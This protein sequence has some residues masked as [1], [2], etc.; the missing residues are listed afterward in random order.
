MWRDIRRA[1]YVLVGVV[2]LLATITWVSAPDTR[3]PWWLPGGFRYVVECQLEDWAII[4][5]DPFRHVVG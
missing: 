1:A 5:H 4:P 3:A 2:A